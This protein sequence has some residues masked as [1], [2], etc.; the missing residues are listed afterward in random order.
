V[1]TPSSAVPPARPK[2]KVNRTVP[3]VDPP[4]LAPSFS[5]APTEEEIFRA[6]VFDE[7]LVPVGGPPGAAENAALAAAIRSYLRDGGGENVRA[8]TYFIGAHPASAW[9]ASLLASLGVVYRRTGH[10]SRALA[11][12]SEAWALAKE[13]N[14]PRAAA[15]ADR[16]LGELFELNARLG[17]FDVL[18]KMFEGIKGRDVRGSATEKVSGARQALWL[19]HNR[20]AE[21]FRCGPLA[22]DSILRFE[23][24]AAATPDPIVLC[25]STKQGTSLTQ[26][27]DVADQINRP[28]RIAK[29]EAGA[30]VYTPAVVH[31]KV[32]HF[33]ALVAVDI[34]QA[35][36]R[37]LDTGTSVDTRAA[38]AYVLG[39]GRFA[40]ARTSLEEVLDDLEEEPSVR[41]HAAEALAYIQARESVDL[42]LKH[43][44]D[45]NPGVTYWCTFAL[46]QIG[47]IRAVPALERLAERVGE[48]RYEK[49]SLRAEALDAIAE[50]SQRRGTTPAAGD[51]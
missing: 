51:T 23:S 4:A 22:I 5:P 44:A 39:F 1:A 27:R 41:G 47:D 33:A 46:G 45:A 16:A 38:A 7:P 42:L 26:L 28:M 31:W 2:V 10:V 37:L 35:L 25:K 19:M 17:R 18:E 20:T 15:T 36:L 8:L 32:G 6:R 50:I 9:R 3:S 11:A 48:Q 21:A 13:H 14:E 12:W 29:R 40:S 34:A 43:L 49:Y 30:Y 24:P